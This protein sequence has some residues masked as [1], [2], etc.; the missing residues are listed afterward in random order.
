[1]LLA[2]AAT[3]LAQPAAAQQRASVAPTV[4]SMTVNADDGLS[5]GSTLRFQVTAAARA[6]K[7]DV[8]LGRS[9]IVVPLQE[10]APGTYTGTYV[11]R[12]A[13]HIDPTQ[14]ISARVT[15]AAGSQ[16]IARN[17]SYPAGFQSL[18]MGAANPDADRGGERGRR[19]ARDE[20]VPQITDLTPANGERVSERGRTHIAAR[21]ADVG[22]GIDPSRVTVRVDGRDV[23]DDARISADE[24][25]LRTDLEP[26]RY[27]AEVKAYD[28]AGNMAS[29]AWTFDVASADRRGDRDRDHDRARDRDHDRISSGPLP[30]QITSHANGAMVGNSVTLE[31]RTVPFASVHVQVDS[32]ANVGGLLG[33]TQPVVD[34]TV[35]ADRNGNFSVAVA[36]SG[37]ALPG[38]RYDVHMTATDGDQRAE[39]RITLQRRQG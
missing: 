1:M 9:G 20:H 14:L 29:K 30:L 23:T 39:E 12:R 27:T 18:A 11:V 37:Y 24:V 34:R 32:V 3:F 4:R 19:Q 8:V 5:P 36:P 6:R 25:N 7:V 22:S 16:T 10:R 21:L 31:G 33:V 15:P 26:G 28:K 13:D 38:Q 17:F 35:Q 2:P